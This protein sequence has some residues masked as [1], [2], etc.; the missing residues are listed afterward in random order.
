VYKCR[1]SIHTHGTTQSHQHTH[2]WYI[3]INGLPGE[4]DTCV[5]FE[6][7]A[8]EEVELMLLSMLMVVATEGNRECACASRSL[9]C[10]L[11]SSSSLHDV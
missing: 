9:N 11:S 7:M 2:A 6:G 10:L 4:N 8:I 1:N 5:L 3:L